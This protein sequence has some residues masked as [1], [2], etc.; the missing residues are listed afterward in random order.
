MDTLATR[1]TT[2]F[3]HL[4]GLHRREL[5]SHCY[6]MLGSHEDPD[7]LV[8]ETLLRA[9]RGWP[10]FENRSTFR[11][12][13]YQIANNT[14]RNELAFRDRRPRLYAWEPVREPLAPVDVQP[15]AVAC[16]N[17][18]IELLMLLIVRGL[19]VRQR[20]ALILR[21]LA[22]WSARETAAQ[23]GCTEVSANS[24]LQRARSAM[25]QRLATGALD[26]SKPSPR[27]R[28]LVRS[29]LAILEQPEAAIRSLLG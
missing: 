7:D 20:V 6:R 10:A 24:L 25:R 18:A 12:W 4:V 22:G 19:P 15:D 5:W 28:A 21:D 13:L 14:W 23:L 8:Q 17:E 1:D 9:W 29:H 16:S 11:N 3:A 27:E 26:G 2:T